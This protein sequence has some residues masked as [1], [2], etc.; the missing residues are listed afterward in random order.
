MSGLPHLYP[1]ADNAAELIL[2][3]KW[4]ALTYALDGWRE[5]GTGPD[6]TYFRR[7]ALHEIAAWKRTHPDSPPRREP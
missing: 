2:A 7:L 4:N 3:Q 1:R 6:R 5:A